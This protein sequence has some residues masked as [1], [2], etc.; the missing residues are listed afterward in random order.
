MQSQLTVRLSDDL[1]RDVSNISKKLHVKRSY[2]V[3]MALEKFVKEFQVKED[4][5]PYD[6]VRD[7]VGTVST[8]APDLGGAHRKHLLKKFRKNA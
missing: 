3:R 7:L 8:G 1:D 4:T 5:A 2:V 6:R